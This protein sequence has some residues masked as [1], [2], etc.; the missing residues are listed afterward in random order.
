MAKNSKNEGP[1]GGFVQKR[2]KNGVFNK[3]ARFATDHGRLCHLTG[4]MAGIIIQVDKLETALLGSNQT[5][6][7]SGE[8][9]ETGW[10]VV[11]LL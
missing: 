5:Q 7:F 2:V 4:K 6:V 3:T 9:R 11:S 10:P 8:I 1:K